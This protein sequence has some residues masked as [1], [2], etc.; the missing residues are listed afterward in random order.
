MIILYYDIHD[1]SQKLENVDSIVLIKDFTI[2]SIDYNNYSETIE[3]PIN[4][5]Y[6]IR[7]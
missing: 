3:I 1:I 7:K 4:R 5:I 6:R 2:A